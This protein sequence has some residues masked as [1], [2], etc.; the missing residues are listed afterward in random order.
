M[1]FPAPT[2]G[3]CREKR[4]FLARLTHGTTRLHVPLSR[5]FSTALLNS[6]RFHLRFYGVARPAASYSLALIG[7]VMERFSRRNGTRQSAAQMVI[8]GSKNKLHM[9]LRLPP[10]LIA[11]ARLKRRL[12]SS[13]PGIEATLKAAK[14]GPVLTVDISISRRD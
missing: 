3:R 14:G 12:P 11:A 4:G 7:K 5:E 9:T 6:V 10:G 1:L 8:R 13:P 2:P